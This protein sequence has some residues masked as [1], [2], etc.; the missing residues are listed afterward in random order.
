M[1][2]QA[3]LEKHFLSKVGARLQTTVMRKSAWLFALLPLFFCAAGLGAQS[4]NGAR[5]VFMIGEDEYKTWETLPNFARTDLAP[6]GF[7]VTIVQ[8]DSLDKNNFPGLVNALKEADLLVISLRRRTPPAE[9][10]QAVRAHLDSGK[11]LIGIRTAC[12]AFA[13]QPNN[14]VKLVLNP[15]LAEWA[16]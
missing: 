7:R 3:T 5:V 10:L 1:L 14:K 6:K 9:Q 11:P 13:L 12:H 2:R 15:K 8:A 16:E 4:K